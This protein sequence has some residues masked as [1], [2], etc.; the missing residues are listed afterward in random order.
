M[1]CF[2][3]YVKEEPDEDIEIGSE[4]AEMGPGGTYH[5]A[6]DSQG[7]RQ[8]ERTECQRQRKKRKEGAHP[9]VI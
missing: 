5:R 6:G 2:W 8:R 9:R 3:S 7:T 4:E 1:N